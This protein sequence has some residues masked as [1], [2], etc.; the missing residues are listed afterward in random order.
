MVEERDEESGEF[1]ESDEDIQSDNVSVSYSCSES[2]NQG[3]TP[4]LIS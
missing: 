1:S 4:V 3:M 2:D